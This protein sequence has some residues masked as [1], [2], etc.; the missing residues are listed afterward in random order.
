MTTTTINAE[1]VTTDADTPEQALADELQLT[2]L[3]KQRPDFLV[4][5]P[6]LLTEIEIPHGTSAASLIEPERMTSRKVSICRKDRF[7]LIA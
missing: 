3:I 4:R 7:M 1:Q 5:H 6:E 2:T